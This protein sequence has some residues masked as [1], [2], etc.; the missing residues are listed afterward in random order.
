ME[1]EFIDGKELDI[2]EGLQLSYEKAMQLCTRKNEEV[3]AIG[4]SK[5]CSYKLLSEGKPVFESTFH[6]PYDYFDFLAILKE[7]LT[8][9]SQGEVLLAWIEEEIEPTKRRKRQ[10]K[11][12]SPKKERAT[13]RPRKKLAKSWVLGIATFSVLGIMGG[14]LFFFLQ[15]PEKEAPSLERLLQQKDYVAAAK[16]YP[17]KQE[18]I[19]DQQLEKVMKGEKDAESTY[20]D[21]L[22]HID[23]P[24]QSFDLA[25]LDQDFRATIAAYEKQPSVIQKSEKRMAILG[26]AY[27]KDKQ[28]EKAKKIAKEWNHVDLEKRIVQWEQLQLAIHNRQ[29]TIKKLQKHPVKHEKAIQK[30]IERLF[31]DKEALEKL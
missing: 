20:R 25:V 26:Y 31:Q 1:I 7:E 23:V 5:S 12:A 15:H 9:N 22:K 29:K 8:G 27:L 28:V 4:L 24:F 2:Q 11:V 16:A 18:R 6:F 17:D 14:L 19:A 30:E 21:F 10:E 13:R 3:Y